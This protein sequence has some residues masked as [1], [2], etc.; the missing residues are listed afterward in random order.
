MTHQPFWLRSTDVVCNR[1]NYAASEAH[2]LAVTPMLKLLV[3]TTLQIKNMEALMDN[4]AAWDAL[5][6]REQQE[7]E[8]VLRQE[9]E[10]ACVLHAC[11]HVG[12]D[13]L[14]NL[15][16]LVCVNLTYYRPMCA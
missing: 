7:K 4:Q 16:L 2:A 13:S 14:G 6:R 12:Q 5:S 10:C 9:S 15:C 3:L 11:K 1:S 8:G